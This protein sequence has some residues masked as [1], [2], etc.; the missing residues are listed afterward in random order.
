[1][2]TKYEE[3]LSKKEWKEHAARIRE[4]D[5][6][7]CQRCG[8][9]HK[10][11]DYRT[12]KLGFKRGKLDIILF[13]KSDESSLSTIVFKAK[14]QI[15]KALT[16]LSRDIV[17]SNLIQLDLYLHNTVMLSQNLENKFSKDRR[18]KNSTIPMQILGDWNY[19]K[20]GLNWDWSLYEIDP[21]S[22]W[23]TDS[24][25]NDSFVKKNLHVHHLCYRMDKEIWEQD[26]SEYITLCNVCHTIVHETYR[27]PVYTG[28]EEVIKNQCTRCGGSGTLPK[29]SYHHGGIC[30]DCNG[31]GI[32]F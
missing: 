7:T 12:L 28:E 3:L 30:F 21:F 22:C 14:D 18:L 15:F 32:E 1:V 11:S 25:A 23:L 2:K 13:N 5:N 17:E 9:S 10:Q 20:D 27:I 4:R 19:I 29:Y 16:S 6:N 8:A 24:K 26:E 31:M